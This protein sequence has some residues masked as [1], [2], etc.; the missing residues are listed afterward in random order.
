[1][2]ISNKRTKKKKYCCKF[3]DLIH[4]SYL[5]GPSFK[6]TGQVDIKNRIILLLLIKIDI[7]IFLHKYALK[8][9]H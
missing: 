9:L 3:P 4:T 8:F 5:A 7:P 2:K 6:T 1:M